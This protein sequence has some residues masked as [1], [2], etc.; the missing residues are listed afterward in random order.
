[1]I[2]FRP[3]QP[4][5]KNINPILYMKNTKGEVNSPWPKVIAREEQKELGV[6]P[7]FFLIRELVLPAVGWTADVDGK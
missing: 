1:M 4:P 5:V 3:P 2:S 6:S 7:S